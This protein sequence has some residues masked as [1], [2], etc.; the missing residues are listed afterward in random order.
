MIC[1]LLVLK[2]AVSFPWG[3][4]PKASTPIDDVPH[5]KHHSFLHRA[6]P[7]RGKLLTN[8]IDAKDMYEAYKDVETDYQAKAFSS[9]KWKI[10]HKKSG[11]EIA[12][13]QHPS[14][15]TCPYVRMKG[16]IPVS[17]QEC[18]NFLRISEWDRS[19]P[20]MDPFYEGVSVHG[21]WKY[22]H[23]HMILCR[24]RTKRILSFAKRD[25]VF[26]SVT[27]KP[28]EDGSLVSG[29]VSVQTDLVPRHS[30]YTRAFQ[31]SIAFY[32]PLKGNTETSLTIVCR[33]DLNDSDEDGR[34]GFFPMWLY[35]KTIG[36]TGAKSVI[37]MRNALI[38]E[39]EERKAR[40]EDS[41]SILRS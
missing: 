41:P 11:V 26:L 37:S 31:D 34:G 1:L 17:P 20:K 9:T 14:D 8:P 29:S 39:K 24:K 28:L 15:K 38:Q 5:Q 2:S 12:I 10:L 25:L 32:K 7:E 35:V 27:D 6:R 13:L 16:I 19:M 4:Q 21:E 30:D 40:G 36:I 22:K 18:W 33:I 23:I 3:K